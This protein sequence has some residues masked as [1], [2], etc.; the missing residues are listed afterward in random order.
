MICSLFTH[1]K[2]EDRCVFPGVIAYLSTIENRVKI[3][4]FF[5]LSNFA[6][7]Q[8]LF[9]YLKTE[10]NLIF[11]LTL[12]H[13][14]LYRAIQP[15]EL[16]E[17]AWTKSE[18]WRKSPQLLKLTDH[19]TLLTYWVSRSIVETESLEERMAMFNRVLEVMSVFEELH[20]FTGL[21]AFYSALNS[22]CVFRLKW[23]WEV[24]VTL[25]STN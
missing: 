6:N 3:I 8:K 20:N 16:V 10:I 14:D 7:V 18:K 12:L 21:V 11:K 15:I 1:L 4:T 13:F 5:L 25:D 22:S 19:S 2:S 9:D 17:A 23:C 24:S